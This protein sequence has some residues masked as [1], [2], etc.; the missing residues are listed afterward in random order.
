MDQWGDELMVPWCIFPNPRQITHNVRLACERA[1]IDPFQLVIEFAKPF[2]N[3]E[4]DIF[5]TPETIET[6]KIVRNFSL[7][8]TMLF[9]GS[10][11]L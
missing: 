3:D 9:L 1:R 8:W 7:F 4:W 10:I 11:D 6:A 5:N 2:Q